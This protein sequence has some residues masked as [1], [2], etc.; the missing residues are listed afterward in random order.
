MR[1]AVVPSE[2][3]TTVHVVVDDGDWRLTH[4]SVF[5]HS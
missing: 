1:V 3:V 5:S 4:P 2:M